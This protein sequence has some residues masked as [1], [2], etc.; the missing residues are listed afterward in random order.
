METSRI[1][2][3]TPMGLIPEDWKVLS[4]AELGRNFSY[5]VGAEAIPYNG[6][7][8]YIRITDIDDE[9]HQFIP[10]PLTSPSFYTEKHMLK[11]GDIVIA[12]TGASVGKSYLYDY[13]DGNLIFAGFLMKFNVSGVDEKYISYHFFTQRYWNWISS[14]SARTGQPGINI[15]QLKQFIIPCP[16]DENEQKK[17]ADALSSVDELISAIDSAIEKKR[18]I[19]EGMIQQLLTGVT[20]LQGFHDSW[21]SKKMWE[22][23]AWDK[24]FIEVE[25]YKQSKVIKYPYLLAADLVALSH[26]GGD[27]YLLS[28]GDFEGWTTVEKAGANLCEGE[29]VSIPWGGYANIKYTKGRFVTADNRIATS[30]DTTVLRNK[31]LYY[32]MLKNQDTINSFYRGAGL[33]HPSMLDVLDMEIFYPSVA[34]QDAIIN[35]LSGIEDEISELE[36]RRNKTYLIKQGMLQKLLTGKTRLI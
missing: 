28:T 14:E 24:Y 22:L 17:I 5:G 1:M 2:Q 11:P 34:E 16:K 3:M 26:E 36:L 9:S 12:R 35:T 27:V 25:R 7:D 15:Q 13:R 18:L 6:V 21:E 20:R 29:V 23:T 30:L 31:F 8:K 4:I 32:F 19:R 10:N 33:Q